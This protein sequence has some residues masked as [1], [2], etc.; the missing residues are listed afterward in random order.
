MRPINLLPPERRLSAWQSYLS[1]YLLGIVL[2]YS[3]LLLGCWLWQ[4]SGAQELQAK[5]QATETALAA[6]ESIAQEVE[7]VA[8]LNRQVVSLAEQ[9]ERQTRMA[10]SHCV[11]QIFQLPS[12]LDVLH[13]LR[14]ENDRVVLQARAASLT[15][16]AQWQNQLRQVVDAT[17]LQLAYARWSEREQCYEFSLS[18]SWSGEQAHVV[19]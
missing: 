2:L 18:F 17:D 4:R 6:L 13:S 16:V 7:R 10:F 9:K 11:Q 19:P 8:E 14:I 1:Y 12:S 3:L 5:L 15:G